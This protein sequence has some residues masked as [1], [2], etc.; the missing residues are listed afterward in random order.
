MVADTFTLNLVLLRYCFGNSLATT[1]RLFC[2]TSH[3]FGYTFLYISLHAQFGR[4]LVHLYFLVIDSVQK[5]ACTYFCRMCCVTSHYLATPFVRCMQNRERQL[6]QLYLAQY[7]L[8]MMF[9]KRY[10]VLALHVFLLIFILNS[11]FQLLFN[12]FN[13]FCLF[14]LLFFTRGSIIIC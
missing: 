8:S 11:S 1:C 13:L 6:I 9:M 2:V 14:I 4:Q 5:I 12:S 3:Y 7:F 10:F